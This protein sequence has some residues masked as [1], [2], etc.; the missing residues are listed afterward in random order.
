MFQ[1]TDFFFF[2]TF[3]ASFMNYVQTF[4]RFFELSSVLNA[5]T[6]LYRKIERRFIYTNKRFEKREKK[7][8][9]EEHDIIMYSLLTQNLKRNVSNVDIFK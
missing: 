9:P 2:E 1:F 6:L 7:N 4:D 8:S 3:C 5:N